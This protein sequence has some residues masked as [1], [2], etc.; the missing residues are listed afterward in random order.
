MTILTPHPGHSA[1]HRS[2]EA[3]E[4]QIEVSHMIEVQVGALAV[5]ELR[6]PV[7]QAVEC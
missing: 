4:V 5:A 6:V 2:F 1:R 7:R 3:V